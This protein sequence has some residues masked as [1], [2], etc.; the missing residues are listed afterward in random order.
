MVP[1][2]RQRGLAVEAVMRPRAVAVAATLEFPMAGPRG[3]PAV[4]ATELHCTVPSPT[5]AALG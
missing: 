2:S 4:A 3:V 5:I 1:A